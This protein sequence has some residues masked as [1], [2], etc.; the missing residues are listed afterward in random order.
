[1]VSIL[2]YTQVNVFC[3][4]APSIIAVSICP[5]TLKTLQ[6]DNIYNYHISIFH[7]Y[8]WSRD[9]KEFYLI[10]PSYESTILYKSLLTHR[11]LE[12][13]NYLLL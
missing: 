13:N 9:N 3:V 12:D 7:Y 11:L 1:M 10:F 5:P 4:L 8:K 6:L 2:I